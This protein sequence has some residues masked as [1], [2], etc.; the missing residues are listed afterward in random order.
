MV[1]RAAEA[2]GQGKSKHQAEHK[3]RAAEA[4]KWVEQAAHEHRAT[5]ATKRGERSG[6]AEAAKCDVTCTSAEPPRRPKPPRW[7]RE[8]SAELPRPLS[9]PPRPASGPLKLSDAARTTRPPSEASAEPPRPPSKPPMLLPSDGS[10]NVPW[11]PGI[12]PSA[13]RELSDKRPALDL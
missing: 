1:N 4:A 3:H 7:P 9:E 11:P 10:V 6:A 8:V 2:T 5:E 12:E 13:K